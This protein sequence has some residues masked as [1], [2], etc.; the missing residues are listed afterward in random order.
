[1][2]DE[3]SLTTAR[4]F[5][6]RC[7]RHLR[8]GLGAW[9][10]REFSVSRGDGLVTQVHGRVGPAAANTTRTV[11]SGTAARRPGVTRRTTTGC[12]TSA[13]SSRT[14]LRLARP[15]SPRHRSCERKIHA[16]ERCAEWDLIDVTDFMSATGL[17]IGEAS[18]VPGDALDLEADTIEVC[19]TVIRSN[20]VGLTIRG[21]ESDSGRPT[22][23]LSGCL[24]ERPRR[25]RATATRNE[26]GVI[27][28][29]PLGGLRDPSNSPADLRVIFDAVGDPRAIAGVDHGW[30]MNKARPQCSE[31]GVVLLRL[32][33]N[34]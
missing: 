23:E 34:Q 9:R 33:S 29:S 8:D 2:L 12:V 16:H 10:V 28:T 19:G 22:S 3:R 15:P 11:L 20:G 25:R 31:P 27:F 21:P 13:A 5:H 17:R 32:D 30:I 7:D 14:G 26:S 6:Y 4:Q 24:T 1:M 18:A